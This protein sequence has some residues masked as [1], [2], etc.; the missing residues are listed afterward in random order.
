[1]DRVGI[2]FLVPLVFYLL[3]KNNQNT[4]KHFCILSLSKKYPKYS[5]ILLYFISEQEI[6][7]ILKKTLLYFI[8][9]QKIHKILK[10]L[11]YFISEQKIPKILKNTFVF[12]L[13]A[14]NNQNTQKHFCILS[15]SKK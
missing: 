12:Y 11:L 4:Q 6:P 9:Y 3:A 1:M 10:I 8:S 13:L 7:K 2:S 14:K 15:P 5:K